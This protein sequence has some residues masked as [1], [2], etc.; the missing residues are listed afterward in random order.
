M[1]RTCKYTVAVRL[2]LN[3]PKK[4]RSFK[5]SRA[6]AIKAAKYEAQ[7]SGHAFVV[8]S[9]PGARAVRE[10]RCTKSGCKKVK[11]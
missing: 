5:M 2:D 3:S 7:H 9:C 1:A 6:L 11:G 4:T 8:R 10:L